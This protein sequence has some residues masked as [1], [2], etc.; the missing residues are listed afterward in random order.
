[1][2]GLQERHQLDTKCARKTRHTPSTISIAVARY[3]TNKTVF[4]GVKAPMTIDHT[5]AW[6]GQLSSV[7]M[8]APFAEAASCHPL[9]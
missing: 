6:R 5:V 4:P 9:R 3:H 2:T 7:T 8:Q 1:M